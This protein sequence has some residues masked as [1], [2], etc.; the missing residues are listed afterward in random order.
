MI[1]TLLSI[2]MLLNF[3]PHRSTLQNGQAR[4][5][6][7]KPVPITRLRS[8]VP[9][10]CPFTYNSDLNEPVRVL[11]RDR[12]AWSEMWKRIHRKGPLPVA[13]LPEINFSQETVVVVAMGSRPTGGHVI[14]IDGVYER[15]GRLKVKVSSQSAGKNCMVTQAL[16]QPVDIVR[17]PKSDLPVAFIENKV[18]HECK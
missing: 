7:G 5:S 3:F 1:F 2:C 13:E 10:P 17:I 9:L 8:C 6:G 18:V 12:E 4:P 16:T 15:D 11:I 14:F